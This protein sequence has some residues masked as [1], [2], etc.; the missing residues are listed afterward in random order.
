[1]GNGSYAVPRVLL[2]WGGTLSSEGALSEFDVPHDFMAGKNS[3][4]LL[5]G[6]Q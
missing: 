4:S 6:V 3:L 5:S 1:M 2:R